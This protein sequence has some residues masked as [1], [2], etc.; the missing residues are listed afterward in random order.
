MAVIYLHLSSVDPCQTPRECRLSRGFP[1]YPIRRGSSEELGNNIKISATFHYQSQSINSLVLEKIVSRNNWNNLLH[2][3]QSYSEI[4]VDLQFFCQFPDDSDK[5]ATI[6]VTKESM[7]WNIGSNNFSLNIKNDTA[8][9]VN[10][11]NKTVVAEVID[12]DKI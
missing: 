2:L 12:I 9:E 5:E 4:F 10:A 11:E 7:Y 1:S 6:L 3:I 8:L